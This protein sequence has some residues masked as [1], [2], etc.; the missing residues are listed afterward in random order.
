MHSNAQQA[1]LVWRD[2]SYEVPVVEN[3]RKT[4]KKLLIGVSGH[5]RT[6]SLLALMGASGAGKT[7]L[8]DVLARRKTTG[9]VTGTVTLYAMCADVPHKALR[10][11]APYVH[12]G[13][14]N[15]LT[16]TLSRSQVRT[17]TSVL[18]PACLSQSVTLHTQDMWNSSTLCRQWPLSE[19]LLCLQPACVF[20]HA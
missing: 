4:P 18:L 12:A 19:R 14:D 8:L 13:M 15:L 9:T 5:V 17:H 6:G 2:L 3:G 10:V 11:T 7:T 1:C 20:P 16:A